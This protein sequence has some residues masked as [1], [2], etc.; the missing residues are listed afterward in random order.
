MLKQIARIKW[1][2]MDMLTNKDIMDEILNIRYKSPEKERELC[3]ELLSQS[4]DDYS[5]AFARTYLADALHSLGLLES[6]I[7]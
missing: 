1:R 6:A 3:F 5:K 4:D 2:R 7:G